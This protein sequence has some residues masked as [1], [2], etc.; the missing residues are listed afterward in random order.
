MSMYERKPFSHGDAVV[1][2]IAEQFRARILDYF[3]DNQVKLALSE[4][5]VVT[6]DMAIKVLNNLHEEMIPLKTLPEYFSLLQTHKVPDNVIMW[7]LVGASRDVIVGAT[8][9]NS[10]AETLRAMSR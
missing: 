4:T 10:R 2:I 6:V 3:F 7:L 5:T 8:E 9:T 1:S